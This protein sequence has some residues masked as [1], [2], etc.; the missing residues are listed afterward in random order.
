MFTKIEKTDYNGKGVIGLP[1]SP[2]LSTT[3]MQEKFEEIPIEVIIPKFNGLVDELS[4]ATGASN[5]GTNGGTVQGDI[6][7]FD[8]KIATFNGDIS[9]LK[10]DMTQAQGDI[11]TLQSG[12]NANKTDITALQS[13]N[14]TNKADIATNKA[15]ITALQN[16]NTT[17]KANITKNANDISALQTSVTT[18]ANNIASLQNDNTTN[19]ADI[20]SLKSDNVTLKGKAHVHANKSVID[21]LSK[22]SATGNLMFEGNPIS[23]GGSGNTD[24]YGHVKVGS[25]TIDASGDDTIE[26]VAGSNVTLT[27][28]ATSKSVTISASG[29]GGGTPITVD[30]ELSDTSTNPVQNKVITNKLSQIDNNS[31]RTRRNITSDLANLPTAIAEQDLAK[32]GY[33]IGDYFVGASGYY[34]HLGDMDTNYGG[35]TKLAVVNT[36]HC[37]IVVDTKSACQW[38]SEGTVTNYSSS[39]LH[40]FLTDTALPNIKSDIATLFGDWE[41]HL[42]K[43]TELD[44]AIGGWGTNGEGLKDCLIC[45]MT[46][47]QMYGARI[48]G[49]DGYQTGTGCKALELFKK[50]RFNEIYGNNSIWLKSIFSASWACD[51][52]GDGIVDGASTSY[53]LRASG[54]ILFH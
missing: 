52:R 50:Y 20:A 23:G 29:G 10:T 9:Q 26:L 30:S 3:A 19:K 4:S 41:S 18:N 22:D 7:A 34:Y 40:A 21:A 53:S 15:N 39:T 54:L 36:H 44:N 25:I 14:T 42:L 11:A 28:N 46:E 47:V 17:N 13:D 8:G 5:I 6:D 27:P 32:Y 49:V 35:Y 43:R 48:F 51:A 38:L 24:S 16:E 37:G 31:R 2:Q 1:D 45:A 33:A 12:V